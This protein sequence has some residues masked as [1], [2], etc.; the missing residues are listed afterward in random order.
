MPP[1]LDHKI[2]INVSDIDFTKRKN[3]LTGCFSAVNR[4]KG[5]TDMDTADNTDNKDNHIQIQELIMLQL[6]ALQ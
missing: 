6:Q 4:N 2:L 3:I 1:V 5:S